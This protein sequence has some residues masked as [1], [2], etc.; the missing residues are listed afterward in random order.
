M[1][2]QALAE[3]SIKNEKRELPKETMKSL[4][5]RHYKIIN[6]SKDVENLFSY[7]ALL[8]LLCNTLIICCIGFLM[9]IVGIICEFHVYIHY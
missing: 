1:M 5:N 9:I 4:V 8:Q 6:F 3:I 7:I 2:H